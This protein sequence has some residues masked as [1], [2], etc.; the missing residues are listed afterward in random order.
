MFENR[1][2]E[3]S[4]YRNY[5]IRNSGVAS[6]LAEGAKPRMFWKLCLSAVAYL[7]QLFRWC[8]NSM[9]SNDVMNDVTYDRKGIQTLKNLALQ[10]LN[11][12]FLETF[13]FG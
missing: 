4:A 13:G 10:S 8:H 5:A 11:V 3:R 12:L 6:I 2:R 1:N 7:L 9:I